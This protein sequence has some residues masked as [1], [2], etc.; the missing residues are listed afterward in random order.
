MFE[1][2]GIQREKERERE[3]VSEWEGE[4]E[5][6]ERMIKQYIR[7]LLLVNWYYWSSGLCFIAISKTVNVLFQLL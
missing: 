6:E 5:R 1:V 7:V 4:R 2:K 3:G